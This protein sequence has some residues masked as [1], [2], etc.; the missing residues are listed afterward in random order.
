MARVCVVGVGLSDGPVT[1]GMSPTMLTAQ[2]FCRA[3]IDL[4]YQDTIS[5]EDEI[6]E[7]FAPVEETAHG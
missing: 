7:F 1:P 2:S 5:R 3:L 6:K 4:G